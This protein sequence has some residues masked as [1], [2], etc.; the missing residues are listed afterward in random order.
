MG[1]KAPNALLKSKWGR[2][3]TKDIILAGLLRELYAKALAAVSWLS[4]P[5]AKCVKQT[6]ELREDAVR[7]QYGL[8]RVLRYA[9]GAPS[10]HL[11]NETKVAVPISDSS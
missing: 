1:V 4:Y 3:R 5:L 2:V 9:E 10:E 11:R 8:E 7:I 6:E